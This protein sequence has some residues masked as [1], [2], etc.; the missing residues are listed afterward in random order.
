MHA[1]TDHSRGLEVQRRIA[2]FIGF[3]SGASPFSDFE[4]IFLGRLAAMRASLSSSSSLKCAGNKFFKCGCVPEHS[5]IRTATRTQ[6]FS[7]R[8]REFQWSTPCNR[9][10]THTGLYMSV[11]LYA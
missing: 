4:Y 2:F 5:K 7:V 10:S 11:R 1:D 6:A 3:L 8:S 9:G